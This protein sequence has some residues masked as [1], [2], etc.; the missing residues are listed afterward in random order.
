MAKNSK[1]VLVLDRSGSMGDFRDSTIDAVNEYVG[2][3]KKGKKVGDLRFTMVQFDEVWAR[4]R[5][6]LCIDTV[7]DAVPIKDVPKL[8]RETFVP[9]GN[10]PLYDAIGHTI[11]A[12]KGKRVLFIIMTDGM[13][14]ASR[15][16]TQQMVFDLIEKKKVKDWTFVF[17]GANQDSYAVGGS[18]GISKQNIQNYAQGQEQNLMA[19]VAEGTQTHTTMGYAASERFFTDEEEDEKWP[20]NVGGLQLP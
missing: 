20:A 16:Y 3:L 7:H 2:T 18:F 15:E 10:T 1:V 8:T 5:M 12:T 11:K 9:R 19:K 4:D 17:L 14:N 13:E 6:G